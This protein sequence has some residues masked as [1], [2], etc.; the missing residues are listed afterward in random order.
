[1]TLGRYWVVFLL[2]LAVAAAVAGK[3][4]LDS[5]VSPLASTTI[6]SPASASFLVILGI[7]DQTPT[8]WDGSITATGATIQS[9]QGWRFDAT[10][11]ISA[12]NTWKMGTRL[13]PAP[14]NVSGVALMQE[15]GLIVTVAASSSPVTFAVKT[16]QGN[17]SFSSSDVPFGASKSFLSGS[18]LVA[19]TAAPLQLTSD[20]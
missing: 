11:S 19:Q 5:R 6:S 13:A 8:T 4:V 15:N 17:F 20:E 9:L 1:M 16:A 12:S 14:P 2:A 10:D 3:G 18:V 7:G